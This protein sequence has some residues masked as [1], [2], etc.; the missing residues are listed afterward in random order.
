MLVAIDVGNTQTVVGLYEGERLAHHFRLTTEHHRS[1]DEYGVLLSAML[2][3][4]GVQ[5]SGINSA[6]LS[7]VVPPLN[8]IF[9]GMCKDRFGVEPLVV[10]PGIKTGMPIL[11]ESPREVGADRIVNGVAGYERFRSEPGG[12]FGV[13][14]VDFG[15]ATTFDVVSPAGEYLG[16]AIAPGV[17]ISTEA[18]FLHASKLPRVDLVMPDTVLGKN[19][20]HSMQAGILYG[21]RAL[22]D[23]VVAQLRR[24]VDF[25]PRVMATGGVA[26]VI[27]DRSESIEMVDE[28]LT[29]RGLRIIHTRNHRDSGGAR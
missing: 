3:D 7:S 9:I 2:Q 1:Q 22:V 10:G 20:V 24:E 29:L 25:E 6:I 8:R 5:A 18:L 11:Y 21:Y 15:T 16:G 13:I 27:A 26:V 14:I 28:F 19:T 17:G 12:P 23:G 4:V